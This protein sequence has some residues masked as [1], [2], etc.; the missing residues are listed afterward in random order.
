MQ[1]ELTSDQAKY[2][3][4]LISWHVCYTQLELDDAVARNTPPVLTSLISKRLEMGEECWQLL[5][6]VLMGNE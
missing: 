4:R 2:L 3:L 6:R 1:A 5:D